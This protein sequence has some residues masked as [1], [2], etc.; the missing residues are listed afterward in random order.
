MGRLAR[1]SHQNASGTPSVSDSSGRRLPGALRAFSAAGRD[2]WVALT[3]GVAAIPMLVE[4][5]NYY[6]GVLLALAFLWPLRPASGI[7]LAATA[8]VSN[9]V[10]G[11]VE[12]EED[13]YLLITIAVLLLVTHVAAAFA[14]RTAAEN[15]A[16]GGGV[17]S[18]ATV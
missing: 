16:E 10:L 8:V 14:R 9:V 1:G 11:L 12:F 6:Y 3:L 7:G 4:L 2:D 15:A 5:S 17:G 13:R 18:I